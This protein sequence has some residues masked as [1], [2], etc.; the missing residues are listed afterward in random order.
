MTSRPPYCDHDLTMPSWRP[1]ESPA[2]DLLG[3]LLVQVDGVQIVGSSSLQAVA[4]KSRTPA[5]VSSAT[6]LKCLRALDDAD[7]QH[8]RRRQLQARHLDRIV[9]ARANKSRPPRV[10]LSFATAPMSPGPN[11]CPWLSISF[12]CEHQQPRS[13]IRIHR[14]LD[15]TVAAEQRIAHVDVGGR[16]PPLYTRSRLIDRRTGRLGLENV[17]EQ[18]LLSGRSKLDLADAESPSLDRREQVPDDWASAGSAEDMPCR[19]TAL[20]REKISPWLVPS[21]SAIGRLLCEDLLALQVALHQR[22]RTPRRSRPSAS[23]VLARLRGV[24]LWGGSFFLLGF[25]LLLGRFFSP[26]FW[27]R[28]AS[29]GIAIHSSPTLAESLAEAFMSTRSITPS[30]S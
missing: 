6:T 9:G 21:L 27:D 8:Q 25:F 3:V 14:Y 1:W 22:A 2:N 28:P 4:T 7:S 16:T 29:P 23:R 5:L 15:L 20:T 26:S 10:S 17:R 12:Q 18:L 24:W 13:W 30:T 11:C 19:D